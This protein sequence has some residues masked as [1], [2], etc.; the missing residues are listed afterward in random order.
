MVP[1]MREQLARSMNYLVPLVGF[2][3]AH[4]RHSLLHNEGDGNPEVQNEDFNSRSPKAAKAFR[5]Y[6]PKVK[7]IGVST[8][9]RISP[10]SET[11]NRDRRPG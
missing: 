5:T 10:G 6:S 3:G 2:L 8:K 4:F 7:M 1:L 11:I 9:R